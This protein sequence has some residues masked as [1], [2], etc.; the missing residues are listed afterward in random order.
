[1]NSQSQSG[2]RQ[3]TIPSY[4]AVAADDTGNNARDRDGKT[5]TPMDQ[6]S[7]PKDIEI[8]RQIRKAVMADDSLSTTA[9]NIKII[10]IDGA[11]TLR[12]PVESSSERINI[13]K[14]ANVIA[15]GKV[16]N[17]LEVTVR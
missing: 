16:N 1:M 12:G 7:D 15:P 8:T 13:G 4:E 5:L 6:S 17:Q 11:A 3:R 2:A 14:K 9:K 10:T